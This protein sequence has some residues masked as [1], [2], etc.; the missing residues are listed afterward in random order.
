QLSRRASPATRGRAE[1]GDD[2]AKTIRLMCNYSHKDEQ[3]WQELKDHLS[4]L[5]RQ[6]LIKLW[7]DRCIDPGTHWEE[8]I[9]SGVSQCGHHYFVCQQIFLSPRSFVIVMS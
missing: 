1:T 6:G 7:D 5:Q 4:P 9:S 8:Q 2:A 3:L